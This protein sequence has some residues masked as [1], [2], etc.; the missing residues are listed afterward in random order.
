MTATLRAA[1]VRGN[2][3]E[4]SWSDGQPAATFSLVWLRDN[5]PA[6][7]H[8]DTK[9]RLVDTFSIA[10]DVGVLAIAVEDQGRGLKVEWADGSAIV[11]C[12]RLIN[13]GRAAFHV[14][15]RYAVV[16]RAIGDDVR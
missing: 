7:Q 8:P 11:A 12:I 4:L 5:C 9:Q 2:D 13:S 3:V 15:H 1:T 16:P 10:A 6:N 14:W